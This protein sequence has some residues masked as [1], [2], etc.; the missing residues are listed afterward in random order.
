MFITTIPTQRGLDMDSIAV[1][2]QPISENFK[3]T[4]QQNSRRQKR[5]RVK[6]AARSLQE[7]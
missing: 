3:N 2:R 1:R 7:F 5:S 4:R 6:T